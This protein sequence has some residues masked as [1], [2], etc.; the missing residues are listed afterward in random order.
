MEAFK[1]EEK[2]MDY[3]IEPQLL[4]YAQSK[5]LNIL[6]PSI[7][8]TKNDVEVKYDLLGQSRMEH[9][10]FDCYFQDIHSFYE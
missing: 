7:S 9:K 1:G 2:S 10:D 4:F 6:I 8:L 3:K 5:T